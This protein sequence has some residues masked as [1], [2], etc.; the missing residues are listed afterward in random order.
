MVRVRN[1]LKRAKNR[2]LNAGRPIFRKVLPIAASL[3]VSCSPGI[4]SEEQC[5]R[6]NSSTVIINDSGPERE[7]TS[8]EELRAEN[9][10]ISEELAHATRTTHELATEGLPEGFQTA[11]TVLDEGCFI[12]PDTGLT[13]TAYA[14]PPEHESDGD[15][16]IYTHLRRLTLDDFSLITHE[17][18]HLQMPCGEI[19]AEV[20]AA[21]QMLMLF[22]AYANQEDSARD[23]I[24]WAAQATNQLYGLEALY[25]ALK[26]IQ[27]DNF[28]LDPDP[29][30]S[31]S[32]HPK[33]DYIR[34]DVFILDRLIRTSGDFSEIRNEVQGIERRDL[35][36]EAN[37]SLERFVA[38]Y[39]DDDLQ[40]GLAEIIAEIRMAHYSEL[41]RRF[42]VEVASSYFNSNSFA[43]LWYSEPRAIVR[44][45]GLAGMN[46]LMVE[47]A[48]VVSQRICS[49]GCS[50]FGVVNELTIDEARLHCFGVE[51]GDVPIFHEWDVT[52]SGIKHLGIG[53]R[54]ITVDDIGYDAIIVFYTTTIEG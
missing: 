17:I 31:M 37:E 10:F 35:L 43:A 5:D 28:R 20:N 7:L 24:Q 3:I 34:A 18:G 33:W 52:A 19:G 49:N 30:V 40:S 27:M 48:E 50:G 39:A 23:Q 4:Q 25:D 54:Q 53:G 11:F 21:E 14:I 12:N 6:Y 22:V 16:G 13:G 15:L 41:S 51:N 9:V 2:M 38:R 47:H 44:V 36:I 46:C 26:H 42:G 45:E 1:A 32:M 8:I 29:V